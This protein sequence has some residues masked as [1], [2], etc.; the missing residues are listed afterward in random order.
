MNI[1]KYVASCDPYG[2]RA[3][4]SSF[5]YTLEDADDPE[6]LGQSLN[7]LVANEGEPALM[8][9]VKMH[10][11][12]EIIIDYLG[13]HKQGGCGCGCNGKGKQKSPAAQEY[14]KQAKSDSSAMAMP[15]HQGNLFLIGGFLLLAVAIIA[16]SNKN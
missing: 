11:D 1:Y 7:D 2:A 3:L 13:Q 9:I 10:P 5:G 15:L 14:V 8:E 4:I 12:K 16:T 6:S